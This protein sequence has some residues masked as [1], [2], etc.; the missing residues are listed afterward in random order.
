MYCM[1]LLATIVFISGAW[2]SVSSRSKSATSGRARRLAEADM[3]AHANADRSQSSATQERNQ[4][5]RYERSARG[6]KRRARGPEAR[7]ARAPPPASDAPAP[8]L[9]SPAA[10]FGPLFPRSQDPRPPPRP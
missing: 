3:A 10:G 1:I 8:H 9:Q 2:Y 6:L 4:E 5:R 7:G